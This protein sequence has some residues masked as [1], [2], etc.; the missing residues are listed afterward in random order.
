MFSRV[1]LKTKSKR[2]TLFTFVPFASFVDMCPAI[3]FTS[4]KRGGILQSSGFLNLKSLTLLSRT[5]KA[6][7]FDE[8]SLIMLIEN[9]ITRNHG[10][11]T[12]DVEHEQDQP[13]AVERAIGFLKTLYCQPLL[14]QWLK[15]GDNTSASSPIIPNHDMLSDAICYDVMLTKMLRAIPES[16]RLHVVSGQDLC[17]WSLLHCAAYSGNLESIKAIF[18]L[19][20]ESEYWGLVSSPDRDCQQTALHIAASTADSGMIKFILS[21]L[22]ESQH[23]EAM[24][25]QD[26]NER[27]VLHYA[28]ESPEPN[29]TIQFILSLFSESQ[30]LQLISIQD[31]WGSTA[32]HYVAKFENVESCRTILELLPE[33]HRLQ[34][35]S[36]HDQL[37]TALHCAVHTGSIRDFLVLLPESQRLQGLSLQDV[38]GRTVLHYADSESITTV[39]ESLPEAQRLQVVCM[40]D[41]N[42]MTMLQ[43]AV[44]SENFELIQAVLDSLPEPQRAEV[45]WKCI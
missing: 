20:P 43:N 45:Y 4:P 22:P 33:A 30:R 3:L 42:G 27:T 23:L 1:C 17:G 38:W 29:S 21:L 14:K 5:C 24:S 31:T 37:Q 32:L 9:E 26:H 6:H 35:V 11:S 15:R 44:N 40:G 41:A 19:Y 10:L 8:L 13:A 16:Q 34:V 2:P 18:S 28:T 25:L 7:T 12:V 36:V 39:L